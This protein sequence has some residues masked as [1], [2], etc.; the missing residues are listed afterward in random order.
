MIPFLGSPTA[1]F[2][3]TLVLA[4]S[5][6]GFIHVESIRKYGWKTHFKPSCLILDLPAA[7]KIPILVML[8]PIEFFGLLL[9]CMILS[10][11]LFAEHVRG[12]H[13]TR[14]HP[15][16]H[17]DGQE[18]QP[19]DSGGRERSVL[20]F[21]VFALS[22]LELFVAFLQAYL[23]AFLAALFSAASSNMPSTRPMPV[24]TGDGV[25]TRTIMGTLIRSIIDSETLTDNAAICIPLEQPYFR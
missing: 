12:A 10:V 25:S 24:I 19:L 4:M 17:P 9:K 16:V 14:H 7:I 22:F 6:F 23:F 8:W 20:V 5:V 1:S 18:L 3:V 13:R 11:R 21:G 2:T 15:P